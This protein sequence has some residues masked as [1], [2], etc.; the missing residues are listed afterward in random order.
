MSGDVSLPSAD[1][2]S[3]RD[4]TGDN[5]VNNNNGGHTSV[6]F[7]HN[8]PF[9][10]LSAGVNRHGMDVEGDE[11]IN[12]HHNHQHDSVSSDNTSNNLASVTDANSVDNSGS[13]SV[14]QHNGDADNNTVHNTANGFTFTINNALPSS[15]STLRGAK[16]SQRRKIYADSL[17]KTWCGLPHTSMIKI[18]DVDVKVITNNSHLLSVYLIDVA[19][20][21]RIQ[22]LLD[23]RRVSYTYA[24]GKLV[25]GSI[26]PIQQFICTREVADLLHKHCNYIKVKMDDNDQ[27]AKFE[28]IHFIVPESELASIYSA[29]RH[30]T[31]LGLGLDNRY[32]S[33]VVKGEQGR[34]RFCD[35][36]L[37]ITQ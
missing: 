12:N 33:L 25:R 30:A 29:A 28:W 15:L 1:I 32:N 36:C 24:K 21:S 23:T 10:V 35:R 11:R 2:H 4:L 18:V 6:S 31:T 14:Q 22:Q 27:Y 26:G 7:S 37:S 8:N 5:T 34:R 13:D 9:R 20:C 17:L 16:L 3:I 19:E